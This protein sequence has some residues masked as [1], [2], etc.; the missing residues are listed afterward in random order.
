[1][2]LQTEIAPER[3][4]YNPIVALSPLYSNPTPDTPNK[5]D[6]SVYTTTSPLLM[7]QRPHI[8]HQPPIERLASHRIINLIKRILHHIVGIQLVDLPN[9]GIDIRLRGLSE[10]Q[11]LC[12]RERL[13]A[14]QA[15]VFG[16]E[17]FDT[18]W[19]FGTV[20]E[21][22]ARG[23]VVEGVQAGGE[24]VDAGWIVSS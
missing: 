1:M 24:S 8:T 4:V 13:E 18:G 12:A 11:E 10:Q 17:D 7:I 15:E 23:A 19:G 20:E 9:Y 6:Y 14:L 22:R 5:N 2:S 3:R 21:G 16:F